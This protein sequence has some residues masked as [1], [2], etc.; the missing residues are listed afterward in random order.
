M[1]P[2]LNPSLYG[3]HE[4]HKIERGLNEEKLKHSAMIKKYHCLLTLEPIHQIL[5][6]SQFGLK[7]VM[8][9]PMH[10]SYL[11]LLHLII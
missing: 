11:V 7:L 10:L 1:V 5:L 3:L 9:A 8:Q 2:Q 4:I 6:F